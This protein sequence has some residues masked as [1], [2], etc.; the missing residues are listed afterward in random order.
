MVAL[1]LHHAGMEALRLTHH[2]AAAQIKPTIAHGPVAR[3]LAGQVRHRQAGLPA[4]QQL[5]A[6]RLHPRIDQHGERHGPAFGRRLL[7]RLAPAA[8]GGDVEDHETPRD[9]HLGR[10]QPGAARIL[11]GVQHI[12]DQATHLGIARIRDRRGLLFQDGM[13]HSG[14]LEYG[15]ER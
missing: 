12:A 14:D 1:V 8:L 10:G 15:H 5:L 4:H 11:H 13:A 7:A 6:Q 9:M 2:L 3:H